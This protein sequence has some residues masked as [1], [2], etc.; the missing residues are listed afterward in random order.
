TLGSATTTSTTLRLGRES[1]DSVTLAGSG[2]CGAARDASNAVVKQIACGALDLGGGGSGVPEGLIPDGA[3]SRALVGSCT[4]AL[5]LLAPTDGSGGGVDCTD[6]GC[7]FGPP[8]P[9][10]NGG[11]STCLVNTFAQ[12]VRRTL[13]K[14]TRQA[15]A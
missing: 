15:A 5:C 7:N 12:P 6:T 1:V 4:G 3:T 9:I 11:L 13:A 2:S 10:P 14:G 8:L